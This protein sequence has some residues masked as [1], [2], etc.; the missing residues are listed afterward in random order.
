M[1]KE[2]TDFKLDFHLIDVWRKKYP[3]IRHFSWFNFDSTIACRL[4][5]FLV[6]KTVSE[7][8]VA[9]TIF[10]CVFSE[11]GFVSLNCDFSSIRVRGPG[12]S[13]TIYGTNMLFL[14]GGSG[15]TF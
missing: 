9:C 12:V 8:T 14:T 2:L 6:S 13:M 1:Q 10:P 7:N 11:D 5:K 4:D 3:G 15:G